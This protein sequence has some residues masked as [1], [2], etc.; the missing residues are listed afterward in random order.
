M[1]PMEALVLLSHRPSC[2]AVTS[3]VEW[4]RW[5]GWLT[6]ARLRKFARNVPGVRE[7]KIVELEPRPG[8]V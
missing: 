4:R 7:V 6:S 8:V 5:E 1:F 2:Q 3:P